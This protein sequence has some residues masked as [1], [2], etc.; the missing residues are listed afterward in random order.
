[1]QGLAWG[2]GPGV[3]W[4]AWR[5]VPGLRSTSPRGSASLCRDSHGGPFHVVTK[6]T[7]PSSAEAG[8]DILGRQGLGLTV[9]GAAL[10]VPEAIAMVAGIQNSLATCHTCGFR[11]GRYTDGRADRGSGML[12]VPRVRPSQ[13]PVGISAAAEQGLKGPVG[14]HSQVYTRW[15]ASDT[16][17]GRHRSQRRPVYYSRCKT[18]TNNEIK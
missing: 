3:G 18:T 1:M 10:L 7:C 8:A 14:L 5:G 15:L 13:R 4:R 9:L 2:A 6:V 11:A 12:S 16:W 17:Q